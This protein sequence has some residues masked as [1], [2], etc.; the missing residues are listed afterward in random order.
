MSAQPT[1][2]WYPDPGGA[3][4]RY[5]DGAAWTAHLRGGQTPTQRAVVVPQTRAGGPGEPSGARLGA[6]Q[7]VALGGAAALVLGLFLP[8]ATGGGESANAFENQLPWLLTGWDENSTGEETFVGHG[9]L[10][11]ALAAAAVAVV[12]VRRG[13]QQ[14]LFLGL[15]GATA[16]AV[17][18]GDFYAFNKQF[19]DIDGVSTGLGL[20]LGALGAAAIMASTFLPGDNVLRSSRV[21]EP[22]AHQPHQ[23]APAPPAPGP[24]VAPSPPAPAAPPE[25]RTES[26][27]RAPRQ[28]PP[29]PESGGQWWNN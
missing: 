2:G 11:L 17:A 13:P 12:F 16:F 18:I 14:R 22:L 10:F 7:I 9:F 1:P 23:T 28:Q 27:P 21:A 5:W 29:E 24:R 6:R 15:A 25:P 26:P 4:E 19:S 8:W 3:G 20:Y